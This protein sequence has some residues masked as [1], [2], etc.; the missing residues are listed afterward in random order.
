VNKSSQPSPRSA[1]E[2]LKNISRLRPTLT[3]VPCTGFHHVLTE[4]RADKKISYARIPGFPIPSV[5]GH[6]DELIFGKPGGS[7]VWVLSGQT[8][9]YEGYSRERVRVL[10]VEL[11][12]NFM[13]YY[14]KTDKMWRRRMETTAH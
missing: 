9:F 11:L 12:K 1:A 14:G 13:R 7:E 5:S 4:L 3:I 6:T 10:A 8:H 2:R